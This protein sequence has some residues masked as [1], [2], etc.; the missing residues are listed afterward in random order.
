METEIFN[1][2]STTS[3]TEPERELNNLKLQSQI[4]ELRNKIKNASEPS[5]LMKD[6]QIETIHETEKK[7]D[8]SSL[9]EDWNMQQIKYYER[10]LK[11]AK[12]DGERK[13]EEMNILSK[14]FISLQSENETISKQMQLCEDKSM[15]LASDTLTLDQTVTA[16]QKKIDAAQEKIRK[17]DFKNDE[18]DNQLNQVRGI[19]THLEEKVERYDGDIKTQQ[20]KFSKNYPPI[21]DNYLD[22]SEYIQKIKKYQEELEKLRKVKSAE[23]DRQLKE[24]KSTTLQLNSEC[25]GLKKKLEGYSKSLARSSSGLPDGGNKQEELEKYKIMVR[26]SV[27]TDRQKDT[28]LTTCFHVFC[29]SCLESNLSSRHRKCP[30]CNI[31]FDRPNMR[32]I[33]L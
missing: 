13:N 11:S 6:Y 15:S 26:C 10:R 21:K 29:K 3:L 33:S 2:R 19:V 1:E 4:S 25:N 18:L 24:E 31:P 9:L 32:S 16:T 14:N 30:G 20:L 22:C 7:E 5:I 23:N 28:V 8:D 27:C 12:E 17:M